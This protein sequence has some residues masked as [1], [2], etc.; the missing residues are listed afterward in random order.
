[1]S[2]NWDAKNHIIEPLLQ[3]AVSVDKISTDPDNPR[4]HSARQLEGLKRSL[5]LYKQRKAIVVNNKD[6]RIE[7]G[8]GTYLAALELGWKEVAAVFV[9]DDPDTATGF[10]I[11]DNR[12]SDMA[13][14]DYDILADLLNNQP[15]PKAIPGISADF[16]NSLRLPGGLNFDNTDFADDEYPENGE[17]LHVLEAD[18]E[19]VTIKVM[20]TQDLEVIFQQVSELVQSKQWDAK[21]EVI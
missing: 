12:L 14:M 16:L 18:Y 6:K 1:M 3:F 13:G 19:V 8:N 17:N 11:A 15:D 9:N 4:I 2:D 10:S 5:A 7:A 21:V 20:N